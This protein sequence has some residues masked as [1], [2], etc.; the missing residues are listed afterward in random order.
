MHCGELFGIVNPHFI[1]EAV[2]TLHLN[3]NIFGSSATDR[4]TT[5][6]RTPSL[7]QPGFKHDLQIM[8]VNFMSPRRLL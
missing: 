4:S 7:T 6:V 1:S 2:N 8:T 5:S 3:K